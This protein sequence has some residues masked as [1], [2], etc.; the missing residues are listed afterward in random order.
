MA[1][2][3]NYYDLLTDIEKKIERLNKMGDNFN[4]SNV[5]TERVHELSKEAS[6][7]AKNIQKIQ[8]NF[9]KV[10]FPSNKMDE[11]LEKYKEF[12]SLTKKLKN[13]QTLLDKNIVASGSREGHVLDK[14]IA[15]YKTRM[16]ELKLEFKSIKYAD[17][18]STGK[19]TT[20]SMSVNKAKKIY[21]EYQKQQE[22]LK[23]I[24]DELARI[25][26]EQ[27]R[28]A[29]L[30]KEWKDTY[31]G[32]KNNLNK[33][34]GSFKNIYKVVKDGTE[35]YRKQEEA[36]TKIIS[37]IGFTHDELKDYRE[38]LFK[39]QRE[40]AKLYGVTAEGLIK[41]QKAY[42]D[43]T[44]KSIILNDEQYKSQ[45]ELQRIMGDE[46]ALS[47]TGE[48][49]KFGIGIEDANDRIFKLSKLT[50]TNGISM[51]KATADVLKNV[52]VAQNYNF[53]QGLSNMIQMTVYTN[54]MRMN[55]QSIA[56]IAD[57]ISTPE[58][59]IET[60]ANLQ[61]LGGNFANYSNPL[62]MLYES[63]ED[64]GGLTER[65]QKMF[66]GLG[67]FDK[68][69][70]EVRIGGMDRMR[71]QGAAKAMGLNYDEAIEMVQ[72]DAKR[73]AINQDVKFNPK[74]SG[75]EKE[76]IETLSQFNKRTKQF[77]VN[78]L[79]KE[80]HK[81]E[82][83]SIAE[84]STDDIEKIKGNTEESMAALV[85]NTYGINDS[86]NRLSA[87]FDANK[88]K[89]WEEY[90]DGAL[91]ALR[92]GTDF[93]DKNGDT[94]ATMA[95][96]MMA[97]QVILSTISGAVFMI[98]AA[99]KLGKLGGIG[100][101]IAGSTVK[102]IFKGGLK[103]VVK[104]LGLPI[105]SAIA[106]YEGYQG[107]KSAEEKRENS[108]KQREADI[109]KGTLVADSD[110]DRKKLSDIN[111]ASKEEKGSSIGGAGGAIGGM[112]LGAKAGGA[113]G[114]LAGPLG[115]GIGALAGG[116]IGGI[117]GQLAGSDI[118]KSI[119]S[120][121]A[122]GD[123]ERN[124]HNSNK[125]IKMD[126]GIVDNKKNVVVNN[127]DTGIYAK[128]GG[129]FDKLFGN[130]IPKI[131]DIY[132]E[133]KGRQQ[134]NPLREIIKTNNSEL[135][136]N[137]KTV[138]PT[139][140]PKPLGDNRTVFNNPTEINRYSRNN[141]NVSGNNDLTVKPI[142]ININGTLKLDLGNNMGNTDI[143]NDLKKNPMFI[144]GLTELISQQIS[145]NK[146][147]GKPVLDKKYHL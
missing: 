33:A 94:L 85:E 140:I 142:N 43:A 48:L 56:Q 88:A 112:L 100:G 135:I 143:L 60:A 65:V 28:A 78:V 116:I 104:K 26:L 131:D 105:A 32:L 41:I 77:E 75:E 109:N 6:K 57:K 124:R 10:E 97:G 30:A 69:I 51:S 45:I 79:N 66:S 2:D 99:Q 80:T 55:M 12:D 27:Q 21:G 89:A 96:Y 122:D 36:V 22:E 37:S 130:I 132:K 52:K 83:K 54:K 113:L 102:G 63:L 62:E 9:S 106:G 84:I 98:L 59:S 108:V 16:E 3:K 103:G 141:E 86:L 44:N 145:S 81:Y 64:L 73:K 114:A 67:H 49:E 68:E 46:N 7:A 15:E 82:S 20:K 24:N 18:T 120:S 123:D 13:S 110:D 17:K 58:S 4:F 90:N 125:S 121:I 91:K 127:R 1:Y 134:I 42:M 19:K 39:T 74:L 128:T 144:R 11:T 101:K 126:D 53:K 40:T 119:G 25:N 136:S 50:K 31:E 14:K 70:G 29:N 138:Y 76:L 8:E 87:T 111:R 147:G 71:I 47:L 133:T 118:G 115:A 137:F 23:R 93:I 139:V 92:S 34:V 129:P 38:T 61:V 117:V 72:N 35:F 95:K 146:N 5:P 107:F